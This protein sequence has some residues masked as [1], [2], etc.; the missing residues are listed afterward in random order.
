MDQ[1]GFALENFDAIG[2]WRDTDVSG[3]PIDSSA[4]LPDGLEFTGPSGLRTVLKSHADDFV[5]TFTE[6]LLTYALGRGVESA[7]APAVRH[8]KREAAQANYRF[9]SFI[10]GI[11]ASLPFQMSMAPPGTE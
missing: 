5:T 3:A 6:K 2:E 7:D 1:L 9:A 4:R 8:I 10:Q 11:V